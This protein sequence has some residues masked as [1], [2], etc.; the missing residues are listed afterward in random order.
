[1]PIFDK[2]HSLRKQ[3]KMLI[4]HNLSK[5]ICNKCMK[6]TFIDVFLRGE[7]KFHALHLNECFNV[8]MKDVEIKK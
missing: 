2:G 8:M 1:M 3:E 5:D 7:I 6:E 4:L